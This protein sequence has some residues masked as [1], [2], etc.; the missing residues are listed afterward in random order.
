MNKKIKIN[1]PKTDVNGTMLVGYVNTTYDNLV[2]KL[3]EPLNGFD[4]TTVHWTIEASDGTV[5]TIYD[6]KEYMTPAG[7]YFW[8]VGGRKTTAALLLV[9]ICTDTETIST[10]DHRWNPYGGGNDQ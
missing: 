2:D 6:Y 3:G 5:A 9:E 10:H 8:H 4:K 1:D 7:K